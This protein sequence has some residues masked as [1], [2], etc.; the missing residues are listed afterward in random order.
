[1]FL[2][3]R[4]ALDTLQDGRRRCEHDEL[5]GIIGKWAYQT[6]RDAFREEYREELR[7]AWQ[8]QREAYENWKKVLKEQDEAKQIPKN[9]KDHDPES[10]SD[11]QDEPASSKL[12]VEPLTP[13][14]EKSSRAKSERGPPKPKPEARS[15][16]P[17]ATAP[18]EHE[19]KDAVDVVASVV[20]TVWEGVAGGFAYLL[21]A[22]YYGCDWIWSF[23]EP[24]LA[25]AYIWLYSDRR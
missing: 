24:P 1:M 23:I 18:I 4:E 8:R 6:C 22:Y 17:V 15:R 14:S 9:K 21:A 16:V 2:G 5:H 7:E 19:T 10:S 12:K 11:T 20:A 13:E 25:D 3:L